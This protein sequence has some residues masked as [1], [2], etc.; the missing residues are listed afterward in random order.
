MG[1]DRQRQP[2]H[3]WLV[4]RLLAGRPRVTRP[5]G[6]VGTP[7][8]SAKGRVI[9]NSALR[10][11]QPFDL[12][13]TGVCA[14]C[15]RETTVQV[16]CKGFRCRGCDS[17]EIDWVDPPPPPPT[18]DPRGKH[19]HIRDEHTPGSIAYSLLGGAVHGK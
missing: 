19:A 7:G 8:G 4:A 18:Q 9:G 2:L 13:V 17:D 1:R 12:Q 11:A 3:R 15:G 5:K 16:R 6:A 14:W 10:R